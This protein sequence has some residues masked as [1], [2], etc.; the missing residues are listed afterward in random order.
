MSF[1]LFF[2][3]R[4]SDRAGDSPE[5]SSS[6]IVSD[7]ANTVPTDAW[8]V[9]LPPIGAIMISSYI[10]AVVAPR[11]SRTLDWRVICPL[12]KTKSAVEQRLQSMDIRR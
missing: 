1:Q 11:L 3:G 7:N 4:T 10:C 5:T 6:S 2:D 8:L 9:R 12:G